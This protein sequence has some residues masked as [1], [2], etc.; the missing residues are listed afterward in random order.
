MAGD[1]RP[2]PSSAAVVS[3]PVAESIPSPPPQDPVG[4]PSRDMPEIQSL[5]SEDDHDH[6]NRENH[7]HAHEHAV[8]AAVLLEDLKHRIIKQVEYYFSDENLPTD[9]H[10][11]GIIKKNKEGFVP[12][13]LIAAFRRMKK[14]T[15]DHSFI[16][17]ALRESSVLVV[18]PNG[19]KVKRLHPI[20]LPETRDSKLF[21]ILVE[22]LPED[23]SEENIQRIFGAAG[24][25]RSITICDPH[26]ADKSGKSG[27]GDVLISNKLHV[28]VEYETFEASEKAVATLND[29][30][31]W[32]N[33]MR[34][35]PLKH[36]SKHGQRKQHR[37]GSDPEKNSTGRVTEQNGDEEIQNIVDH[38]D[39]VPDEEEGDHQTKDK[40]GHRGRNQNQGRT[41]RQ[42]YKGVNGMGHGTTTSSAHPVELSKPPPGPKMP[43]GTRGFTMGRGRPPTSNQSS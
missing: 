32:R 39:D 5:T 9:K 26:A 38:H 3:C 1:E 13:A 43:D 7:D 19:K 37:R 24:R 12:I 23:H 14:L 27:K 21:T 17:A 6:G 25:V 2:T 11:M 30:R 34:V 42:K 18:S 40:H 15:Q 22:N 33:G 20:P 4:S 28:L 35:K 8:R 31:D 10:L 41:R 29:E 16:A 36:L